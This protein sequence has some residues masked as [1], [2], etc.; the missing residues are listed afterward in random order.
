MK[1]EEFGEIIKAVIEKD[2]PDV[3]ADMNEGDNPPWLS[4]ITDMYCRRFSVVDAIKYTKLLSQ[5]LDEDSAI[6]RMNQ[7]SF[8]YKGKR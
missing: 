4:H 2:A 5:S 1:L 3:F 6:I 7:I 8:K